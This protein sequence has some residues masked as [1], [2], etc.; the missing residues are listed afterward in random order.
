M[1]S[2]PHTH[3]L[4]TSHT[5]SPPHTYTLALFPADSGGERGASKESQRFEEGETLKDNF[6]FSLSA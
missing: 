3:A 4:P 6:H 2:P 5:P 1:P